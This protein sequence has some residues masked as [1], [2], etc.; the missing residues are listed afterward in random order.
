VT[1]V[2]P[3]PS[4]IE[5]KNL[6]ACVTNLSSPQLTVDHTL[7]KILLYKLRLYK[8]C[9]GF[10]VLRS[11]FFQMSAFPSNPPLRLGTKLIHVGSEPDPQTG[12]VV[13]PIS[14][15]TTFAQPSPGSHLGHNDPNSHGMGYDYARTSNPTRGAFERAVA[16]AESAEHAVAFSSGC[17]AINASVHLLTPGARIT[18]VDDVYGGTQRIFSMITQPLHS[19][20]VEYVDFS[21]PTKHTF[22]SS[23]MIWLETP[24]NPTLKVTDISLIASLKPATSLLVVDNTFATPY[25][26]NPLSLGADIVV[27]SV[28][29]Y[30]NGHSDVVMGVC[31]TNDKAVYEK[32]RFHQV[33]SA[34]HICEQRR[35]AE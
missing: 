25:F 26:Q 11:L 23:S 7:D 22:A 3:R 4:L 18:S 34:V 13:P 20:S 2:T 31:L 14:L 17:A 19:I 9:S 10:T 30:I 15:A 33:S 21:S 5:E 28:T 8:N 27:H 1:I 6:V 35:K 16:A 32:L 12:A 29:K 24:T